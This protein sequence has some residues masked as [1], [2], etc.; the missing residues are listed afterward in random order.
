MIAAI[1]VLARRRRGAPVWELRLAI[2]KGL[3]CDRQ[4]SCHWSIHFSFRPMRS[5]YFFN[6]RLNFQLCVISTS[7]IWNQ[8]IL[9]G[10]NSWIWAAPF[11]VNVEF[12]QHSYQVIY[13][14]ININN[15]WNVSR[16]DKIC[17]WQC[18]QHGWG[19]TGCC[20]VRDGGITVERDGHTEMMMASLSL[21]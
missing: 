2:H 1:I 14:P 17:N 10:M 3:G 18:C 13:W 7:S 16:I 5:L 19:E 8:N 6:E 12:L 21:Y 11:W 15:E 20:S 9:S 4:S